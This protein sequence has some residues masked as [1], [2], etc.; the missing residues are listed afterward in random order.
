ML[1]KFFRI[2]IRVNNS[3]NSIR[4]NIIING[5]IF[6]TSFFIKS[7]AI[8]SLVGLEIKQPK[9]TKSVLQVKDWLQ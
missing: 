8:E 9:S 6:F 2:I 5:D 7:E 4:R 1:I 3:F